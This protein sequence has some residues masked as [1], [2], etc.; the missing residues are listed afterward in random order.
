MKNFK[1]LALVSGL[2]VSLMP[3]GTLA[4]TKTSPEANSQKSIQVYFDKDQ[5]GVATRLIKGVTYVPWD[6]FKDLKAI[7]DLY[8]FDLSEDKKEVKI[9]S[10]DLS[11]DLV[12]N[13]AVKVKNIFGEKE[14]EDI[15]PF[16][17][18]DKL[19]VPLRL[20]AEKMGLKVEFE[21]VGMI[22]RLGEKSYLQ[23]NLLIDANGRKVPAV[24]TLPKEGKALKAVVMLHG[25]GS[26]KDEAGNG[27]VYMA[28]K[29][30]E[31]KIASIRIDFMGVGD[32]KED[33]I[34]YDY[35]TA[36]E[37]ALAAK[38][39]L[40]SL[41][42]VDKDKIG[43][44]GWSQG[45]TDA[46]LAAA[47][48]E[49][50]KSVL[51]WAGALDLSD[52]MTDAQYKEAEKNGYYTVEFGWRSPLKFGLSWAKDVKNVKIIDKIKGIKAPIMAINGAKDDVVPPK[53]ADEILKAS[54]NK[55]SKKHVIEKADH[56]F[57]I[58]TGSMTEF[59]E[60]MDTTAKWFEKTL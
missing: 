36:T 40:K 6:Y 11:F 16:F 34:G 8:K 55:E 42:Q 41:E 9:T 25:T 12:A 20:I 30:A 23:K 32:S 48:S 26:N 21:K 57:N 45:G 52:M 56:T 47:A 19:Y 10:E 18:G 43:V 51:T 28:E 54:P 13:K 1:K 3:L 2:A 33:Y 53:S 44:M 22:A 37:D 49:D 15:K 35:K 24:V 29:F 50:F 5:H 46:F 39:Y 38:D 58:F 17:E 59:D 14:I 7:K 27:Y 60:L 4:Q 31:N